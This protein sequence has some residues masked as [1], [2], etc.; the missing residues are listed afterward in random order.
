MKTLPV[1]AVKLALAAF[2][3]GCFLTAAATGVRAGLGGDATTGNINPSD[4]LTEFDSPGAGT[5]AGEGTQALDVDQDG[6][7][8]GFF[9]DAQNVFHGFMRTAAGSFITI[10]EPDAGTVGDI[11]GTRTHAINNNGMITGDFS[12]ANG[13]YHGFIRASDGTFTAFDAPDAGPSGYSGTQGTFTSDLNDNGQI[14]GR[15]SDVH[16]FFHAYLRQPDGAFVLAQRG[17]DLGDG[18]LAVT[19]APDPGGK[20]VQATRGIAAAVID[21]RFAVDLAHDQPLGFRLRHRGRRH[22]N[23]LGG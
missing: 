22:A 18:G 10:D 3:A 9:K 19:L 20:L 16:G 17:G 6:N 15:Y 1:C 13:F 21:Q 14:A 5:A 11:P 2:L 4:L 23:P 8:V 12:D 7:V